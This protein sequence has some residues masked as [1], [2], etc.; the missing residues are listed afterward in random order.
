[1]VIYLALNIDCYRVGKYPVS[2]STLL[3]IHL[4]LQTLGFRVL[5][6]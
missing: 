6:T 1:M 4:G 3:Q 2:V 5:H